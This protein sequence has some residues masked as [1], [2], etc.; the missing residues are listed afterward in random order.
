MRQSGCAL[1]EVGTTN[2]TRAA[3]YEA[4]CSARTALLVKV[5]RSNFAV[6]GFSQEA[7]VG[8]LARIGKA[9]AIP[10]FHDLGSGNLESLPGEG[11]AEEQTVRDSIQQGADVVAFSGDKLLGGP[12]S[13]IVVGRADLLARIRE[14]PLNRALR[15]DKLTVAALE[16]TLTLYRDGRSDEVPA[17]ALLLQDEVSLESRAIRLQEALTRAGLE[18]A[19]CLPVEGLVGGGTLPLARPVSWACTVPSPTPEAWQ[20]R[21]RRESTPVVVRVADGQVLLDVRCLDDGDLAAVAASVA[22]TRDG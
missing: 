7:S 22:R 20:D 13:G 3:D 9:R 4:A 15:V 12:Q 5:H 1:V 19:R 16:A 8:E 2:R 21:L 14:H 6:V 17:R 11:L 10:L 18:D